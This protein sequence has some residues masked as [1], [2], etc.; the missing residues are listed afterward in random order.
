MINTSLIGG[1]L[2]IMIVFSFIPHFIKL[3]KKK[4][5][6]ISVSSLYLQFALNILIA[7]YF[8]IYNFNILISITNIVMII[9]NII[10][11]YTRHIHMKLYNITNNVSYDSTCSSFLIG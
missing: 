11:A 5:E 8:I 10:I 4:I 1:C 6:N 7:I 3:Y 9:M 2:S